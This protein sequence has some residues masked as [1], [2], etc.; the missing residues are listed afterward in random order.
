MRP[1]P[2]PN[3]EDL[4]QGWFSQEDLTAW[5]LGE[6]VALDKTLG[7]ERLTPATVVAIFVIVVEQVVELVQKM[8]NVE[9]LIMRMRGYNLGESPL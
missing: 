2:D 3:W 6:S 9:T 1:A 4:F 8:V 5:T 7:V